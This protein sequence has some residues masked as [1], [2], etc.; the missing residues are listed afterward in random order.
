MI[1]VTH[2]PFYPPTLIHSCI[3]CHQLWTGLI[4]DGS[5]WIEFW[6][7][8]YCRLSLTLK[9]FSTLVFIWP[10]RMKVE[11]TLIQT[12]ILRL[13]RSMKSQD[14]S[15]TN[16]CLLILVLVWLGAINVETNLHRNSHHATPIFIWPGAIKVETTL[17]QSLVYRLSINS[18]PR[19]S[20]HRLHLG[21]L[22]DLMVRSCRHVRSCRLVTMET[23][24]TPKK[25]SKSRLLLTHHNTVVLSRCKNSHFYFDEGPKLETSVISLY[26]FDSS[27]P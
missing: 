1:T 23:L 25:C 22:I 13:T 2:L 10:G 3:H 4:F 8:S 14:N 18:H 11:T 19:R 21:I 17:I 20:G 24:S 5:K 7:V 6:L 12:L 26:Y 15:H 27:L 9:F 16:S